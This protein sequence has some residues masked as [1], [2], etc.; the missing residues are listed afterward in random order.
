[1]DEFE[2]TNCDFKLYLTEL[3]QEVPDWKVYIEEV[4]SDPI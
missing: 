4:L 2:V 1:M 3:Q